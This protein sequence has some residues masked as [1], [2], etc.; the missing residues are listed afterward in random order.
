[1]VH[2]TTYQQRNKADWAHYDEKLA[3]YSLPR[4]GNNRRNTWSDNIRRTII[5]KSR[6]FI[7][8]YWHK[9]GWAT[10]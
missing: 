10:R 8:D 4:G 3:K 5:K 2:K 9:Q 6:P 1:L 7:L